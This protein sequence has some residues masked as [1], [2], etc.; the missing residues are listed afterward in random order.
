MDFN[1][2]SHKIYD[3]YDNISSKLDFQVLDSRWAIVITLCRSFVM[4]C[5]WSIVNKL[6]KQHLLLNYWSNVLQTLQNFS[7]YCPLPELLKWLC[8]TE[9]DGHQ[10]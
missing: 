10:N 6:L 9:K 7:T 8:S 1:V 5:G 4:C 3:E 2:T